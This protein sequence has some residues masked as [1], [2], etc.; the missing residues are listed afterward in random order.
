MGETPEQ[1]ITDHPSVIKSTIRSVWSL[2]SQSVTQSLMSDLYPKA[3]KT[4]DSH[5]QHQW[6]IVWL[7]FIKYSFFTPQPKLTGGDCYRSNLTIFQP[8]SIWLCM[9]TY[10]NN[11]LINGLIL[12]SYAGIWLDQTINALNWP[13]LNWFWIGF[14]CGLILTL[15]WSSLS[16]PRPKLGNGVLSS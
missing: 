11:T 14:V 7:I 6:L 9:C 3:T 8:I 4:S 15:P 13:V 1:T 5:V 16:T 12:T 10:I 2:F